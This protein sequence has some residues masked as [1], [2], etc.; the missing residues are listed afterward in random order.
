M[1]Y[2]NSRQVRD[3]HVVDHGAADGVTVF[4]GVKLDGR[5][6][7]VRLELE[8]VRIPAEF[9]PGRSGPIDREGLRRAS[10]LDRNAFH[11]E[12]R[13]GIAREGKGYPIPLAG[14]CRKRL[15]DAAVA[16]RAM[17]VDAALSVG[18]RPSPLRSIVARVTIQPVITFDSGCNVMKSP[19]PGG[20]CSKLPFTNKLSVDAAALLDRVFGVASHCPDCSSR[21]SLSLPPKNDQCFVVA[22][23]GRERPLSRRG[24]DRSA[25]CIRTFARRFHKF[26]D[27]PS[28]G[29]RFM[30]RSDRWRFSNLRVLPLP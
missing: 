16:G 12:L 4:E 3:P 11:L 22:T 25:R 7:G 19:S 15:L 14:G 2:G 28:R 8:G 17:Q 13:F 29:D 6:C 9:V 27:L 18:V 30:P 20:P 23:N 21:Q 26:V 24:C 10:H 1:P 5:F